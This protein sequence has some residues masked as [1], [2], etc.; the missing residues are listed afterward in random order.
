MD[1]VA[2]DTRMRSRVGGLAAMLAALALVVG[3]IGLV[4]GL[5]GIRPW[6]AVLLGINSGFGGV[7]LESLRGI[8]PIDIAL[9]VLAGFAFRGCGPG[10]AG[11]TRSGWD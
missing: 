9:L 7:T 4:I 6:L 11:R 3:T 10:P 1:E 5:S 2:S 8:N